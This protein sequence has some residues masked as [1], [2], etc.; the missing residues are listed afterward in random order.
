MAQTIQTQTKDGY[1]GDGDS[2]AMLANVME[3]SRHDVDA[4]SKRGDVHWT[5]LHRFIADLLNSNIT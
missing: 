2:V 3:A 1:D 5:P 4:T